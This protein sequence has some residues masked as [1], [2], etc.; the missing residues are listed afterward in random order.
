MTLQLSRREFLIA[1]NAAALLAVIESCAPGAASRVTGSPLAG[2]SPYERAL[3][4]L[5]NAVR[6][7]PDHLARQADRLVAA[8][9]ADH[10]VEFVRDRVSV[11]PPWS[12]LDDARFARR[13]GTAATLRGGQGT[14]RDRA[15]LLAGLLTRAGF[16]AKVMA[17]DMPPSIG[18]AELYRPRQ[19]DF[20]A[21]TSLVDA[22][23]AQLRQ[24]GV[25]VHSSVSPTPP[26]VL[27]AADAAAALLA[28]LPQQLQ[29]ARL[30]GDLLPPK[31]P[32]VAFQQ[33]GKT[34]Y[35]F[36]LG[37]LG[38]ADS[39]PAGLIGGQTPDPPV[40]VTVTVSSV[41]NPAPGSHTIRGHEVEL[42]T[43][44]WAAD[45]VVGRQVL[46]T[47]V[48]PSGPKAYLTSSLSS[49]LLRIPV[50]RVQGDDDPKLVATGPLI[51]LQGD[52]A[53]P[54]GG[55]SADAINGPLG[56][57]KVLSAIDRKQAIASV[58]K[59]QVTPN[60]TSFPE[61][62]LQVDLADSTGAPVDGLD[63]A[64]FAVEED[65]QKASGFTL[66]SN[67]RVQKRARVMI[68]YDT[69]GSVLRAWPNPAARAAF[70]QSLAAALEGAAAQ[71]P[72][73]AQVVALGDKSDPA[74]WKPPDAAALAAAFAAGHSDDDTWKTLAGPGL[75]QGVA[76]IVY[77]GDSSDDHTD[78]AEL[79]A[80]QHRLIASR[81]P[82]LVI[83]TGPPA[84]PSTQAIVTVSGGQ[85]LDLY[86]P[87]TPSKVA[88][89][90]KPLVSSWTG[91]GYVLRY[92]A[93]VNGAGGRTVTVSLA[94]RTSMSGSGKYQV[95][96]KPLAPPSFVSLYVR[97]SVGGMSGTRHLAGL[98]MNDGG[99][100]IGQLD[101]PAAVAETRAALD[102]ITTIAIEPGTPTTGAVLD[103]VI[104]SMLSIEPL[105]ALWPVK[106]ADTMLNAVKNGVRRTPGI[107][108]T[109]LQPS[110]TDPNA[111]PGLRVAILH[112]RV[113]SDTMIERHADLAIGTNPM[114]A[115]TSDPRAGF[116]AAL[117]NSVAACAAE[118]AS[119]DDSAYVR[120][121]GRKLG[122]L[123]I[124]DLGARDAFYKTV[125]PDRVDA[126]IAMSA[127][128]WDRHLVVPQAGAGE[129]F[130]VVDPDSGVSKAVLLDGTGGARIATK[131]H[132]S[133]YAEVAIT[134][135]MLSIMCGYAPEVFP[136][137]CLGIT[138]A[139][140]AMT[141]A[142]LFVPGEAD[143]GTPFGAGAG[144]F[145]PLGGGFAGLNAAI[146]V[147]LLIVTIQASCS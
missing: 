2:G 105:R 17:A 84:G 115:V 22:A 25:P 144:V 61:I 127:I 104:T 29:R 112:E 39:A 30:R 98:L 99:Q 59:I 111:I 43:G 47:F 142:S 131:C 87:A 92:A 8:R 128:Y 11:V 103:D 49:Q 133:P 40:N 26:S 24:A 117:V 64:A 16:D 102:G 19:T 69:S 53:A 44:K 52:V 80:L 129:A 67:V 28:A 12:F 110:A 94:D 42:V 23:G 118:A 113:P 81:V 95:P 140:T 88:A 6:A 86:D 10:I 122:A 71:T 63:A 15:E 146:G 96:A 73:D 75:D 119:M 124:A 143:A 46:L 32:V 18:L 90:V 89:F 125:P 138:T 141:V 82:V 120:L 123:P 27:P 136:F 37:S 36:A 114:L 56:T 130:W 21:D 20:K 139:A 3:N 57:I 55:G 58:A 107:L 93:P 91:G 145:N 41:S 77:V 83:P 78:G 60:A 50:L 68:A 70:E 33:G 132:F 108:A 4:L 51:T 5:R 100:P 45:A 38:V 134:L 72:F 137:V 66:F 79:A 116:K 7:S 85:R 101:D 9:D 74:G 31:V 109:L 121:A 1:A 135:S 147:A 126:W 34:R 54:S 13:W 48:P 76:A 65:G 97:I 62:G 14:L 106:D 35:T